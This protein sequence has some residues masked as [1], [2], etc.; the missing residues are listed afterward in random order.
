MEPRIREMRINRITRKEIGLQ[1][2]LFRADNVLDLLLQ[3]RKVALSGPAEEG[4]NEGSLMACAV[5][6]IA[7]DAVV[8]WYCRELDPGLEERTGR[9]SQTDDALDKSLKWLDAEYPAA[10]APEDGQTFEA[11]DFCVLQAMIANPAMKKALGS[12]I[13]R[14]ENAPPKQAGAALQL[15]R[16]TGRTID[17]QDF[18]ELLTEPG[19]KHPDSLAEQLAFVRVRWAAMLDE[20]ILNLLG[21]AEGTL[22][23]DYSPRFFG[24]GPAED[25]SAGL[26]Y[27]ET[28]SFSDDSQWMPNVVMMAKN[29]LVWLNQLSA[30]Y[31]RPVNTLDA[32]PD[33]ELDNLRSEGFNALWLIGLWERS[34]ASR[35]IKNLCGNPE[36]AASA[37]SLRGY[38][39][40][41]DLGGWGALENLR[42]RCTARGIRLASD[43]VPNHT[44]LD[45]DWM[46]DHIDY[47]IS[48]DFSPYPNYTFNG[49]DLSDDPDIEIKLEDHYYTRTD[50][51]TVFMHHDR[52]NGR[53][54]FVFHGN[55]GTSMPWN[56]TAQLDYLNKDT[57]EAV[58]RQIIEVARNFKIIR[59]DAAMTLA[60]KHIRRLWYPQIGSKAEIAGRALYQ[61][62]DADFARALPVEFWREVVDRVAVEA[63]D[64]LLL[65]EA[66]WMME[67]YF[68]RTLGMHR[69]YNSA[70]MNMLKNEDNE[71]YRNMIK[72]TIVFDP[73]ILKRYVN[74]MN[75]PDEEPA[76]VQFGTG[77]KYFGVCTVMATLPGLPMFG[78]GQIEG[79]R[80]KYGMEYTRAYRDESPD[81]GL[82]DRHRREIFPVLKH[83]HLFSGCEH[84]QLFDLVGDG[85][86]VCQSVYAY[87]NGDGYNRNLVLYNNAY[88]RAHGRIRFSAP[89]LTRLPDGSREVRTVSLAQALAV[90]SGDRGNFVVFRQF[91]TSAAYIIP[92]WQLIESGLEIRL[93]GFATRVFTDI[94]VVGDTTGTLASLYASHGCTEPVEDF[95]AVINRSLLSPFFEAVRALR[96]GCNNPAAGSVLAGRPTR[97][98]IERLTAA[99]EQFCRATDGLRDRLL[100]VGLNPEPGER[101]PAARF[102]RCVSRVLSKEFFRI[103]AALKGNR[104]NILTAVLVLQAVGRFDSFDSALAA[105]RSSMLSGCLET[106]AFSVNLAALIVYAARTGAGVRDLLGNRNF[107]VLC[108]ENA[109]DGKLWFRD[110]AFMPCVVANLAGKA[111]CSALGGRVFNAAYEKEFAMWLEKVHNSQYLMDNLRRED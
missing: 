10:E 98:G 79:L 52:R 71:Q 70:F 103:S 104:S 48:Q 19:R 33:E 60:R 35:K 32:I 4:W 101:I 63:P 105:A 44:G 45:S 108:G 39:I 67:S 2:S 29:T 28:E 36:A 53:T 27:E 111:L 97:T 66:F 30:K 107:R 51:S 91:G 5:M 95:D 57:R 1:G 56:D 102:V 18:Y 46:K 20:R 72:K 12:L 41:S 65:A 11:R 21:K 26:S 88:E 8:G 14:A 92:L 110:E 24:P 100:T 55:D 62:S 73:E 69:V 61:M 58:I 87:T 22:R 96:E 43:M 93:D 54:R 47:F 13:L 38:R 74:F 49:P 23:E 16:G 17:G 42:G 89:K 94:R 80:E 25:P 68:V 77:D 76:A 64:T 15:I 86:A 109:W 85:G 59:F 9:L 75:N 83:R 3:A 81:D 90:E 84:F 40:A 82:I 50:A 99:Y 6:H 78:H 34:A 37:Y 7:M 106:D 31:G